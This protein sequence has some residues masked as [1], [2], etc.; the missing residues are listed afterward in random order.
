KVAALV[1]EEPLLLPEGVEL[2]QDAD[3][4]FDASGNLDPARHDGPLSL[5]L[6][7]ERG[8]TRRIEVT[9]YGTLR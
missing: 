2:A 8:T 9:A 3:I 5:E 4:W 6:Q 1:V 7:F